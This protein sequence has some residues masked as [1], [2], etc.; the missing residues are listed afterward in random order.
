LFHWTGAAAALISGR[1][2]EATVRFPSALLASLGILLI[3][4]LGRKLSDSVTGLLAGLILATTMVYQTSGIEARVDM[5]LT[6]W[7]TLPLVLFYGLYQGFLQNPLWKYGFFLAAGISVLAK[8]PVSLVLCALIVAI[9]LALKKRW[10]LFY[11]F[12]LHPGL[13]L[14][15]GAPLAWYGGALWI[16]GEDF[17]GIQ[18]VEENLARFFVHGEGGTGHQKPIYYFIP[19]LF[20]LGMP[21]TL[22]L[23]FAAIDYFRWKRFKD[24]GQLFLGIWIAVIFIFFS[25]SAGKRPPYILPL[26]PPLALLI[27]LAFRGW[28][29]EMQTRPKGIAIVG[30]CAVIIG[31]VILIPAL[32][33]F[34]AQDPWWLLRT[35]ESRLKADDLYQFQIVR[36]AINGTGMWFPFFLW[37]SGLVWLL[38]ARSLF[39]YRWKALVGQLTV[40]SVLSFAVV[41]GVLLPA[42]AERQSYKDFIEAVERTYGNH[43]TLYLFTRGLDFNS[44][45]FYGGANIHV[46]PEDDR[47]L[48]DKLRGTS[49]YVIVGE[50][51]SREIGSRSSLSLAPLLRSSGTG[52]DQESP[53][54]L[55]RG[56]TG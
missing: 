34:L 4:T 15:I 23:P 33:G 55:L 26:Y 41:R 24:D 43:G 27:A 40:L 14:A 20:T 49:N 12:A 8:G 35:M 47:L 39:L 45:I 2:T 25:L 22:L 51:Q 11:Q 29:R 16:A 44:I 54:I 48:I 5:T 3:Y 53:L 31:A 21:W 36:E 50:R 38:V 9:F 19:Y 37:V 18:F 46:L 7:L 17:F 32:S 30:G 10:D 42:I 6:F 52:P 56:A 28:Q 13:V 1:L